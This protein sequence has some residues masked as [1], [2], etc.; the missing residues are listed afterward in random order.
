MGCNCNKSNLLNKNNIANCSSSSFGNTSM[1][2]RKVFNTCRNQKSNSRLSLSDYSVRNTERVKVEQDNIPTR[3][4][5]NSGQIY[6]ISGNCRN[7][8]CSCGS[9]GNNIGSC[10]SCG[11]N[12]SSCGSCGNNIGS[13]SSCGNN[14]GSCG[15]CGNTIGSCDSCGGNSY[16][17][18]S[19]S[20]ITS[21][22]CD[23]QIFFEP[24]GIPFWVGGY[25]NGGCCCCDED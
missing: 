11:N 10:G 3:V 9:C 18:D 5:S 24:I 8:C 2:A 22:L 20:C 16:S 13:C 14:I 7:R 4:F 12:I 17:S 21:G 25:Y 1:T 6:C 23:C 19:Y 15:S